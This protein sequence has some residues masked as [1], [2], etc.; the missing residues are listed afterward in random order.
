MKGFLVD[1]LLIVIAAAFL[2][3]GEAKLEL[4]TRP[5]STRQE[6]RMGDFDFFDRTRPRM[7]KRMFDKGKGDM[8]YLI[9]FKI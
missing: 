2:T 3:E 8:I 6:K 7:G 9:D 5:G 4:I 1:I